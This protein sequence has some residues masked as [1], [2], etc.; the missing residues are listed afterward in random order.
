MQAN[1]RA[2]LL[3]VDV[4]FKEWLAEA[5]GNRKHF[6]ELVNLSGDWATPYFQLLDA[7]GTNA[8]DWVTTNQATGKLSPRILD[9]LL[10]KI[11][12]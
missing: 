6:A 7:K 5:A 12:G 4:Q 11:K 9:T 3:R 8:L 1:L 2:Y 10:E